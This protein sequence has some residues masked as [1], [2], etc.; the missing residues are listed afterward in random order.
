MKR[1]SHYDMVV[2]G[3]G[4]AGQKAA[5]TAAAAGRTVALVERD[6]AIGGACLHRGTIPSK[7]LREAAM[8]FRRLKA[9]AHRLGIE[10]PPQVQL[11]MLTE[12]LTTVI[13]AH[14]GV[15]GESLEAAGVE[16]LQGMGRVCSASEVEVR[17]PGAR[18]YRVQAERTIIAT[19][20]KPRLPPEIPIDHETILDSDSILSLEHLPASLVILGG[21][22]IACEYA[23]IFAAVGVAVTMVDRGERPLMFLDSELSAAF[24]SALT[25]AGGRYLGGVQTDRV[26]SDGMAEVTITLAGGE[27]IRAERALVALGRVPCV[28]SLG[29]EEIGVKLD[30]RQ[31]VLVNEFGQTAVPSVYAVGDVVGAP[32]L[33]S[34]SMQ[35]GRRAAHHA[36]GLVHDGQASAI[37]VGIFTIPEIGAVGL[38]Q[39]QARAEHGSILVGRVSFREVA[40]GHIAGEPDGALTLIADGDGRRI[41]GIGIVGEGAAELVGLGQMT[42]LLGGQVRDFVDHI[43]NFPT[44]AEAYRLAALDILAQAEAGTRQVA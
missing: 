37:P 39:E 34:T 22:V 18:P 23:S 11:D 40:R 13:D 42:M 16:L 1:K 24:L 28:Q 26:V 44:M 19:G 12:H 29:L 3:S 2:I 30:H 15:L 32:A 10:L 8:R 31:R 43:F 5:L 9:D 33:A 17:P 36:M 35:Q 38:T 20:S 7:T 27:E 4:P 6:L 14:V 21:G 41:L 25:D